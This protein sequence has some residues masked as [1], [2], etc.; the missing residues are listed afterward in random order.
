[1]LGKALTQKYDN[2]QG[3]CKL[4]NALEKYRAAFARRRSGVRIPSTPLKNELLD[5]FGLP[6]SNRPVLRDSWTT[7]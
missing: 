4:P 1:M 3:F 5:V 2:L 6:K 7:R